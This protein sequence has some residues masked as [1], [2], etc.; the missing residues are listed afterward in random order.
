MRK[1]IK[2]FVFTAVLALVALPAAQA[3]IQSERALTPLENDVRHELVMLPFLGV[4]DN[5]SY[6]VEGSTVTLAGQVYRPSMKKSADRVVARIEGVE[7][8]VNNIEVLPTSPH[9]DRIR[10]LMLRA[11]YGHPVLGRYSLGTQPAIRIIVERGDVTLEGVVNRELEK[12]VA[13]LQANSVPGVFSVT[14]NLRVE[15]PN[16]G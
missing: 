9:D 15:I 12:N 5:I 3:T 4:F 16:K 10:L 2:A 11:I 14:N 7:T 1:H 8:V 6:R 13:N